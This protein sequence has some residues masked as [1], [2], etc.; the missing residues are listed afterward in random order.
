ME[1]EIELR[2]FPNCRKQTINKF[3]DVLFFFPFKKIDIHKRGEVVSRLLSPLGKIISESLF[4]QKEAIL[5][6][7]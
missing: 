6:S 5:V 1:I 3:K 4:A 2:D 7:A